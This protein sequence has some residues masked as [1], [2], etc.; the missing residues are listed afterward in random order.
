MRQRPGASQP[1]S[2]I[3]SDDLLLPAIFRPLGIAALSDSLPPNVSNEPGD[4][5]LLLLGDM[6]DDRTSPLEAARRRYSEITD[7][8]IEPLF[9]PLHGG[10][11][12][13]VI[14]PLKEAKQCYV[15]GMPVACIAQAGLVG[16]MVALWRFRMLE[17]KLDGRP[18][19]DE[20]QKLLIGREFDKLG[21]EERVRV[22]RA[23]DTLDESMVQAFGQLR[24]IR[25]QYLHFMVDPQRDI[26]RDAREAIKHACS[27]VAKTLDATIHEGRI[28]LP[29]KVMRF[30]KEILKD[31]ANPGP[32]QESQR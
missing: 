9:V 1:Y 30:I 7:E 22:L 10:I 23:L 13:H 6:V 25:R 2:Q 32:R 24:S 20:L 11:M 27:L 26:D 5:A 15:L 14:R 8:S 3:M 17:P 12:Q 19:D 31:N 21:Q 28:V 29:P 18:L 16:E 4:L